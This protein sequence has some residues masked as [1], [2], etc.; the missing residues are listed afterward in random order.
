M[1]NNNGDEHRQDER[2]RDTLAA[3]FPDAA[4]AQLAAESARRD[5]FEVETRGATTLLV[6]L[7]EQSPSAD[8]ARGILRAYGAIDTAGTASSGSSG[9]DLNAA[10]PAAT[11][12]GTSTAPGNGPDGRAAG[13]DETIRVE[14]REEELRPVTRPVVA[15]EIVIRRQIVTETRTIK[16]PITREEL[17]IERQPV[18]HQPVDQVGPAASDPVIQSV[19]DRL[20]QMQPGE[21]LRIPI[22]EEEVIVSKRP[23]VVEEIT[24]RKRLQEE[25]KRFSDTVRREVAHIESTGSVQVKGGIPSQPGGRA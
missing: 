13:T 18:E 11:T 19:M 17:V 2:G 23:V 20:R 22:I 24:V 5:G 7:T 21:A 16:V 4:S 9:A 3:E 12:V 1:A 14:V 10:V 25:T 6:R 8:E 15:G